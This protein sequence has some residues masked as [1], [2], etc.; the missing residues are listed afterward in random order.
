MVRNIKLYLSFFG[1]SIKKM[2]EYRVDCLVGMISQ[3]AF[4]IIELI[5]IWIIFQNTDNIYFRIP[6]NRL[7]EF[8]VL[9]FGTSGSCPIRR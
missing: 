7:F 8:P 2:M 4:Q 5:F 1:A 3:I 6:L 9:L